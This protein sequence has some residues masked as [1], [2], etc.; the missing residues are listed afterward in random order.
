VSATVDLFEAAVAVA[1]DGVTVALALG[2]A[3]L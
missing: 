2:G 1:G 3:V